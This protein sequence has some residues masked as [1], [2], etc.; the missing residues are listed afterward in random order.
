MI[1]ELIRRNGPDQL[2]KVV[3][4]RML[5]GGDISRSSRRVKAY[6]LEAPVIF[7]TLN[8][9]DLEGLIKKVEV[10]ARLRLASRATL[11]GELGYDHLAEVERQQQEPDPIPAPRPLEV[12]HA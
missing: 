7:P 2:Y 9:E 12:D 1:T 3:S 5:P 11:S 4:A 10:A 8:D 6:L